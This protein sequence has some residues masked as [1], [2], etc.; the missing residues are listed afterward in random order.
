MTQDNETEALAK[1]IED[2]VNNPEETAR[3][4]QKKIGVKPGV[5]GVIRDF[6]KSYN[7]KEPNVSDETWLADQFAKPE[8]TDA[9]SNPDERITAAKGIVQGVEDYENAKKSLRSHIED[10]MGSRES[11]LARQI[12]I[13]AEVNNEDPAKYADEVALGLEDAAAENAAFVFEDGEAE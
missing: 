5:F 7:A 1:R 11:W 6:V 13:G 2:A 8:Y 3:R 9:F 10:N 4:I 12:A